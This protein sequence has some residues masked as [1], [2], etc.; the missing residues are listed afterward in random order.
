MP[1]PAVQWLLF[2]YI[3]GE[4]AFLSKPFKSKQLAEK[5]RSKYPERERKKIGVGVVRI[6][7]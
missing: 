4:V 6:E 2:K 7:S 1:K 5:A 3:D